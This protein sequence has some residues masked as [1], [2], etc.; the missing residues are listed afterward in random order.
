MF[1]IIGLLIA[2]GA[3]I[4]SFILEGG[5]LSALFAVPTVVLVF[6]GTFGATMI[7]YSPKDMAGIPKQLIQAIK[8]KPAPL[9]P[10]VKEL[11]EL[12]EVSRREGMLALEGRINSINDPFLRHG[13]ALLVDGADEGR[14]REELDG[15]AGSVE[16]RHLHAA[17][18]WES[19]AG[20]APIF[21]LMGTTMG[22]I[23]MLGHLEDPSHIG[24]GLAIALTATLYGLV[25][26]NVYYKP[27][28][29]KLKKMNGAEMQ[30]YDL[31][32]DGLCAILHGL[33]SRAMTERLEAWLPVKARST[34]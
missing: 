9:E 25:S 17:S 27:V 19:A 7:A 4:S 31:M 3:M 24:H 29:V 11:V 15:Y 18:I 21:G 28:S 1:V 33:S 22:L 26:A 8:G 13:V 10:L 5:N 23:N 6:G 32:I 20:Y 14:I 34:S 2:L 30:A 12:A 16:Q